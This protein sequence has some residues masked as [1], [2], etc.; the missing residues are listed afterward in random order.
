MEKNTITSDIWRS[1]KWDGGPRGR[2]LS[3]RS[4][5][6]RLFVCK[7]CH[8]GFIQPE[9]VRMWAINQHKSGMPA[10]EDGVTLRWLAQACLRTPV[11]EDD[12]DRKKLKNPAK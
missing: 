3:G 4:N 11:P 12:E 6:T 1:H 5:P 9:L 10:L 7:Y 2:A 8:R